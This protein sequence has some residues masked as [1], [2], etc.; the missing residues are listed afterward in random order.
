MSKAVSHFHPSKRQAALMIAAVYLACV[1]MGC[2]IIWLIPF[3]KNR[4]DLLEISHDKGTEVLS[5]GQ[6]EEVI[7]QQ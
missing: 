2:L 4:S 3:M 7:V 1:L 5:A 6:M